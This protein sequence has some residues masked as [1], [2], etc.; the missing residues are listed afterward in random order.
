MSSSQP[1]EEE[2]NKQVKECLTDLVKIVE[3]YHE[4]NDLYD[5]QMG[6]FDAHEFYI[7]SLYQ[8]KES[9]E[10]KKKKRIKKKT[11]K[12]IVCNR[13]LIALNRKRL[14]VLLHKERVHKSIINIEKKAL[15]TMKQLTDECKAHTKIV[16]YKIEDLQSQIEPRKARLRSFLASL[17]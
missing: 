5:K 4:L 12:L 14:N 13:Y 10:R 7:Q 17:R 3:T 1:I 9:T 16:N 8:F 11:K 2:E 15:L 6:L